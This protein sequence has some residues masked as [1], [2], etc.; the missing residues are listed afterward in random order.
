MEDKTRI[1]GMDERGKR[2]RWNDPYHSTKRQ[3]VALRFRESKKERET[4][5]ER[6]REREYAICSVCITFHKDIERLKHNILSNN[7]YPI[8]LIDSTVNGYSRGLGTDFRQ[9]S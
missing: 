7:N 4:E 2:K 5:R 6:E 3:N 8:Q 1:S 9:N